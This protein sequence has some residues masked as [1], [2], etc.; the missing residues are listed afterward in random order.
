MATAAL[1]LYRAH[2]GADRPVV[3]VIYTHS[4]VDR[5]GARGART[6]Q[7]RRGR[8]KV[9]CWRRRF[10][11]HAVLE[12]IYAEQG[13]DA[14]CELH[15][16]HRVLARG[17]PGAR[18]LRLGQTRSTGEVSLVIADGRPPL[19]PGT[20]TIDGWRSVLAPGTSPLRRYA[21]PRFR[22]CAW[23]KT[24]RN[25][26]NLLTPARRGAR[27]ARL[28]NLTGRLTPLPTR[29]TWCSPHAFPLT[30]VGTR[31][32]V[33]FLSQQRD[34]YSYLRDQTLRLLNQNTP[35]WKRDVPAATGAAAGMAHPA[36]RVGQP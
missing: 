11:A 15:V 1:D 21:A 9:A 3:A 2:R 34:M 24:P 28:V 4:H 10:T 26:H 14:P 13:D 25:L 29:P 36:T 35:V 18:R 8:R 20:H 19:G 23:P 16:R 6:T 5:F 17:A 33:E 30:D 32:I 31:K 7:A 22:A 27:S 12:N